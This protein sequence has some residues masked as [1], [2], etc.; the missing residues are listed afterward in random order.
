MR[1]GLGKLPDVFATAVD[2]VRGD[3]GWV[4]RAEVVG[5]RVPSPKDVRS[6]EASARGASGEVVSVSLLARAEVVVDAGGYG[7]RGES[8]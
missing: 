1:D 4:V 6:V 5:P 7:A 8:H 3:R 2:A